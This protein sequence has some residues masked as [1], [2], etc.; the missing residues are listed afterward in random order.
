MKGVY[1]ERPAVR[2]FGCFFWPDMINI[3]AK[4]RTT[5]GSYI[6]STRGGLLVDF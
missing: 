2:N 1:S 6:H 5:T 3:F 4:F